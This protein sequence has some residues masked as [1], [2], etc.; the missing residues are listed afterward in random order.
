MWL[1]PQRDLAVEGPAG[2]T[3]HWSQESWLLVTPPVPRRS[4]PWLKKGYTNST[5][6]PPVP[7]MKVSAGW[8][9]PWGTN[10]GES[11]PLSTAEGEVRPLGTKPRK[12]VFAW[13]PALGAHSPPCPCASQRFL[14]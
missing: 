12:L 5:N 7:K 2:G 14:T 8:P 6:V 1:L 9:L 10:T 4:P 13:V 3:W 11:M